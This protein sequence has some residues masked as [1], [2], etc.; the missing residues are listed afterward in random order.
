M[1]PADSQIL[2]LKLLAPP[3]RRGRSV[4]NATIET[5]D[6]PAAVGVAI[7]HK[8]GIGSCGNPIGS[9]VITVVAVGE[10]GIARKIVELTGQIGQRKERHDF[11]RKRVDA[12]GRDLIVKERLA[13]RGIIDGGIGDSIGCR[14]RGA[15]VPYAFVRQWNRRNTGDSPVYSGTLKIEKP[16]ELVSDDGRAQISAKLM[17]VVFWL[18]KATP[19]GKKV[20]RVKELVAQIFIR[21]AMNLIGAPL[22]GHGDRRAGTAALL[23]GV[24]IGDHFDFLNRVDRRA[25]SLG[26][27]FLHV[28]RERVVIDSVKNEV[29][30]RS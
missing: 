3:S 8:H 6:E 21:D 23:S 1:C 14:S 30:L 2:R 13:R 28:F 25:R 9:P 7:P 16:E 20:V 26:T 4:A 5:R 17:L 15:E 24:R 29:V 22:R 27:Q 12:V 10:E 11:C 18:L 19:V